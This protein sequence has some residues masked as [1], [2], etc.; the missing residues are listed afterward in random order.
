MPDLTQ[1]I[2]IFGFHDNIDDFVY[3]ENS[4]ILV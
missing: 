3:T 2:A 1:Q 4:K